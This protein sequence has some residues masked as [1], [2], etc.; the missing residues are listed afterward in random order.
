MMNDYLIACYIILAAVNLV[1]FVL[2]GFDK[3]RSVDHQDR[4]PEVY[5]FVISIFFASLGVLLGM[6]YFHHKTRKLY[7][8]V[9]LALLMLQQISLL[10]LIKNNL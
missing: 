5:L 7:F 9:A 3:K 6:F 10:V 4:V 2:V 1:A 8:P